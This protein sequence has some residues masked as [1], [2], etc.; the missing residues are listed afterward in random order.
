M[1]SPSSFHASFLPPPSSVNS[2]SSF[3]ADF[4]ESICDLSSPFP[5]PELANPP[6]HQ[7]PPANIFQ[8]SL[9]FSPN[10]GFPPVSGSQVPK[11]VKVVLSNYAPLHS[12]SAL[13]L[14]ITCTSTGDQAGIIT[15]CDPSDPRRSSVEVNESKGDPWVPALSPPSPLVMCREVGLELKFAWTQ[16]IQFTHQSTVLSKTKK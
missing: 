8:P 2:P 14:V 10:K 5:A 11:K 9:S 7:P 6:D 4:I 13:T 3:D 12:T 1:D 15:G 16:Y